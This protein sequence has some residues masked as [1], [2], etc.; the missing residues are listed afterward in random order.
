[1]ES[2]TLIWLRM[3]IWMTYNKSNFHKS[4]MLNKNI[5]NFIFKIIL[6]LKLNKKCTIKFQ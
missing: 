4:M 2:I 6:T 5:T 1:M 3:Q